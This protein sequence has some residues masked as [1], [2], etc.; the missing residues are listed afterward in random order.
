MERSTEGL[1]EEYRS[2]SAYQSSEADWEDYSLKVVTWR[3]E[4]V[5]RVRVR[6]KPVK[7]RLHASIETAAIA[8]AGY[9]SDVPEVVIPEL[10]AER[11]GLFPEL[12]SG[13]RIEAYQTAGGEVRVHYI[14]D[15]LETSV[16]TE[17]RVEGPVLIGVAI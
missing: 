15:A 9:E 12:P 5:V 11:L 13:T 6:L 16:L 1:S 2:Y 4:L 3:S 7:G 17:D 10:L 8:N 14:P